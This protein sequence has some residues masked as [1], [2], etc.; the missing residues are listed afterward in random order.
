MSVAGSDSG[1]AEWSP[2]I[3]FLSACGKSL[4]G[5]VMSRN[6]LSISLLL[7]RGLRTPDESRKDKADEE[8]GRLLSCFPISEAREPSLREL[9]LYWK[10]ILGAF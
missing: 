8:I 10:R 2:S 6:I 9:H 1:I 3:R 7:E 4:A 5:D